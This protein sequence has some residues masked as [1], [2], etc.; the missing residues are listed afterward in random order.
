M[1][2]LLFVSSLLSFLAVGQ[3]DYPVFIAPVM[4]FEPFF[5]CNLS[6]SL[7]VDE[8]YGVDVDVRKLALKATGW[9][10]GEDYYWECMERTDA[11]TGMLDSDSNMLFV[12]GITVNSERIGLGFLFGQVNEPNLISSQLPFPFSE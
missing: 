11:L 12:G 1:L 10:E 3:S 2:L 8:M 9:V 7:N 5:V 6:D 4:D